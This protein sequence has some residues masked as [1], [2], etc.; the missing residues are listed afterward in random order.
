MFNDKL[1]MPRHELSGQVA[2][3]SPILS[4]V[5]CA[6]PQSVGSRVCTGFNVISGHIRF[7]QASGD[8]L[9]KCHVADGW[10]LSS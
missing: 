7:I 3:F 6:S 9:R 8:R 2:D 4:T 10:P 5:N 1:L